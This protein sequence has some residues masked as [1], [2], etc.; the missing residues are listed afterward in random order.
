MAQ[1]WESLPT[2]TQQIIIAVIAGM[3]LWILLFPVRQYITQHPEKKKE[4]EKKLRIHFE[5]INRK[6]IERISEMSRSLV[7]RNNRLVFGAVAPVKEHYT[8]E[9]DESYMSFE[10]HFPEFAQEWKQLKG[11]AIVLKN[12]VDI[13]ARGASSNI[14]AEYEDA[15]RRINDEFFSLQQKYHD[16]AQRLARD[17]EIISKYKIGK[18]FKYTKKCPICKKF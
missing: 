18:D 3:I 14:T 7:I 5:D 13:V 6:V 8:F 4:I 10:V 15:R 9:D 2:I 1:F 11:E 16:F 12:S 17:V